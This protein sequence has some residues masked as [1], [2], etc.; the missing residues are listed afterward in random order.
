MGDR[1]MERVDRAFPLTR[2]QLDIWLSQETGHSGT[3]WQLSL[4]ARIDGTVERDAL[5]EAIRLGLQDAEPCR[6]AFF[7]A[8]GQVFQKAIDDP[9]VELVYYDLTSSSGSRARS[10]SARIIDSTNTHAVHR[11]PVQMGIVQNPNR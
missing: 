3:E 9:D 8:D 4:F 2:R 5:E 1:R 10:P 11:P 6:A 7:E